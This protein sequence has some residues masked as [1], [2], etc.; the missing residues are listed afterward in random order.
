[1]FVTLYFFTA[2]YAVVIN[3]VLIYFVKAKLRG[4]RQERLNKRLSA[5]S[6]QQ[7]AV[8]EDQ[9]IKRQLLNV[10]EASERRAAENFS[11]VSNTLD[12]LTT[13]IVDG[14]SF[15]RE[16]LHTPTLAHV[17]APHYHTTLGQQGHMPSQ[18]SYL[19]NQIH[20]VFP[21]NSSGNRTHTHN[22][23]PITINTA[24]LSFIPVEGPGQ[25]SYTQALFK[26][27]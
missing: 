7:R 15:L 1:M 19:P 4:H 21:Q 23:M 6:L 22:V 18:H 10:I 17:P 5:E 9:R 2:N 27:D 11:K 24:D 26:K 14:F 8:E 16:T 13:S 3:F 20:Q 12:R 25:F